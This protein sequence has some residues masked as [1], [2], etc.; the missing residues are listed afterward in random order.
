MP[1]TGVI[2]IS[3]MTG[4][5]EMN[6][7]HLVMLPRYD[8]P[9]SPWFDRPEAEVAAEFLSA[10]RRVRPDIEQNV[11]R[12]FVHRAKHV[13]ALWIQEPPRNQGPRR[14]ADGRVW[15]VNAEMAGRDTLNNNAIVQVANA[16]ARE[17]AASIAP[18]E[19]AAVIVRGR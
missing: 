7:N 3:S 4:T 18:A 10:L 12:Y 2:E 14:T 19:S 16:A 17:I 9:E 13:Q 5:Q 11:E 15:S 1:F 6:G 8:V